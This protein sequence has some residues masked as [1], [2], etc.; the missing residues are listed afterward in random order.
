ML[1]MLIY[2]PI[3][4]VVFAPRRKR[5]LS[6][7]IAVTGKAFVTAAD[8]VPSLLLA[9]LCNDEIGRDLFLLIILDCHTDLV[10]RFARV[11]LYQVAHYSSFRPPE[12]LEIRHRRQIEQ[13]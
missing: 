5:Y 1:Y 7:V 2:L 4:F 13:I 3:M 12:F 9:R 10:K 8:F 6:L 11:G